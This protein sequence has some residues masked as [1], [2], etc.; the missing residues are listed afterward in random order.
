MRWSERLALI[1]PDWQDVER[2]S[3]SL[4]KQHV[5][6]QALLVV[7]GVFAVLA[8]AGGAYAA[9]RAIWPPHDM[10]PADIERQA[11]LVT[12]ECDGHGHCKPVTASHKEMTILPSMGVVF[13]LPNGDTPSLLPTESIWNIPAA[14]EPA[15][16]A[17]RTR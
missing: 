9:A 4:R 6:R 17:T 7:G 8:L 11:T 3:Q 2:R 16:P 5:R 12:S 10:T 15:R 1:E 14:G 13:V